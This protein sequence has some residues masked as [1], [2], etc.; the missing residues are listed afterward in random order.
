MSSSL[1]C[2]RLSSD[3]P[4]CVFFFPP[5]PADTP[6]VVLPKLPRDPGLQEM[7]NLEVVNRNE[8]LKKKKMASHTSGKSLS[9]PV[10]LAVL[11]TPQLIKVVT[12]YVCPWNVRF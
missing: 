9:P 3:S 11:T 6:S 7:S 12:D 10:H 8:V 4:L 5:A 2:R 1:S